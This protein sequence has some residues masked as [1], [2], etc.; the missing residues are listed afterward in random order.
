MTLPP[1]HRA[2]QLQLRA[3]H[4][5]EPTDLIRD[6]ILPLGVSALTIDFVFP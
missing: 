4:A 6:V 3:H 1:V 2:A 5:A